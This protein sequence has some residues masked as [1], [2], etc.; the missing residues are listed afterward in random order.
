MPKLLRW[1]E[2]LLGLGLA[3][4]GLMI[5]GMAAI[6]SADVLLREAGL[7]A[8]P[9]NVEVS[10]YLLF[11]STCLGAPWVLRRG[12]HV[13]MD[14]VIRAVPP[15]WARGME[16][17]ASAVGLAV[18]LVL[19]GYGCSAAWQAR[20]LGS[21]IFKQLVIPEW[22]LLAAIP[23]MSALLSVEFALRLAG[24]VRPGASAESG[25]GGT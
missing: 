8:L 16:R 11:L 21:L 25:A 4:A 13:R 3:L 10:E 19:F 9:W 20:E 2:G 1:Y 14:V 22:P 7:P 15:A 18:S 23:A 24:R 12:A 6:V 17:T 5:V